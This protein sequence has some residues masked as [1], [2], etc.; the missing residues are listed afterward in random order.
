MQRQLIII[1]LSMMSISQGIAKDK[2]EAVVIE[3]SS[4]EKVEYRLVDHPKIQ[5]DGE[6]ITLTADGVHVE[7][8]PLKLAKISLC[9]V[10]YIS[11]GIIESKVNTGDMI[12]EEGLIR[13]R[14]FL[15]SEGVDL[16]TVSGILLSTYHILPDGT[17]I[18]PLSALPK[19][20]TVIKTNRQHIKI[21]R[22]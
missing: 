17:L 4:G 5:Y 14:G 3:L 6:N 2:V 21:S 12:V 13:M 19:G 10:E 8:S 18:I 9:E 15:P 22:Q 11:S 16:Y 1:L 20:I 7:F